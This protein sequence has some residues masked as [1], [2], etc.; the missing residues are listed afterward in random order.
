VHSVAPWL[1]ALAITLAACAL[2]HDHTRLDSASID[3]PSHIHA[4][5][6][7]VFRQ[8]AI[9]NMEHPPLVKELAGLGL[10]ACRPSDTPMAP[11]LNFP[12]SAQRFLFGNRVSPDS[13]LAAARAPMLLF[14]AALCLLVFALARRWFGT[15]AG[16]L[17]LVLIAFEP[18]MLA[19][20]GIVHTDVAVSL[21]WLASIAAWGRV[22]TRR[23]LGR[24][25]IAGLALGLALASK[26]SA[27]YLFPTLILASIAVR[28]LEAKAGDRSS[29][30]L[31]FGSS[32]LRDLGALGAAAAI[33]LGL[34]LA[35][36]QPVVSGFAVPEQQA[37]IRRMIGVYD[38]A[39][40]L[41]ER[42]AAISPFSKAL[43]HFAGGIAFVARQNAIG[44]GV[45]FLNGRLS[46]QGFP[47]YF[48]QAVAVKT[49]LP[50]LAAAAMALGLSLTRRVDR[51]DAMLWVPLL[52]Y[53]LFSLGSSFN[54]GIRHALPI[55]PL[56]AIG[57][58]RAVSGRREGEREPGTIRFPVVAAVVLFAAQGATALSSHP[59][60]L[61]YFNVLG[62]GTSGGYRRLADSN[63]DWGLDL[64]RLAAELS[65][66]GARDA[67]ICYFGG[68]LVYPRT[69]I[70]DFAA[71]PRV[72]GDLVAISTTLWDIGPAFY[73]IG[74]RM[75]LARDLA[76]LI[77]M[78]R[79]QGELVGR[80]GGSTLLYRLPRGPALP[81]SPSGPAPNSG[82]LPR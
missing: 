29:R 73:A 44:G 81:A 49:G 37:V 57:A 78:L 77:Q 2:V 80:I 26:F 76:R 47:S 34:V 18:S 69:G 70:R 1:G 43:A 65:K 22:L 15:L 64:R 3:E 38:R 10:L 48:P 53:F 50:L 31:R 24:I 56:M 62:G 63:T 58:S 8:N 19:H 5:Y 82:I 66:R 16:Y 13:L 75:D 9:S 27:V 28:A 39:P 4:A 12:A 54:I 55:Y 72:H 52:Y 6:L 35:L 67:T 74:G 11:D 21:F 68:D 79:V 25:A 40:E 32:L 71:D 20:A 60:E 30:A 33:A 14:F 36:Y 46:T 45:T 59:F 17:A 41:A 42:I 51:R 7:Q 61:S 23:T